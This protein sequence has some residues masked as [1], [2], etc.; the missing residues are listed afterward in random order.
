MPTN[1]P[2]KQSDN[3]KDQIIPEN[4]DPEIESIWRELVFEIKRKIPRSIAESMVCQIRNIRDARK[5]IENDGI[6]VQDAKNNAVPHPALEI[7]RQS[8]KTL[9]LLMKEW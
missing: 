9:N 4:L 6:V 2:A 7:E 1:G 8:I 3:W 5:A